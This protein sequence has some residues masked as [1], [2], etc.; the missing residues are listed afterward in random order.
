MTRHE[1][2]PRKPTGRTTA[3]RKV[4]RRKPTASDPILTA[5]P[6]AASAAV[7]AG[8][9][10]IA[11]LMARVGL[12]SRR[13]AEAWIVDGRV[14]LNGELLTSPAQD[15]GPDDTILVD[16]MPLPEAEKTRLFLFHKPR[17]LVTSDHDPEGRQT[18]TDYLRETWPEGRVS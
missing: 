7:P 9:Q 2:G 18:V 13:D 10:R 12:C 3:E 5:E 6:A 1:N 16:G 11:K 8:R 17:G 15:V 14:A 4:T